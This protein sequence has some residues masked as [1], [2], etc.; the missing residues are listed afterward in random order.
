MPLAPSSVS[1]QNPTN[2]AVEIHKTR[3]NEFC[4]E[5][6]IL[7]SNSRHGSKLT[8]PFHGVL[9]SV[10]G[11]VIH[12]SASSHFDGSVLPLLNDIN[13][14]TLMCLRLLLLGKGTR[15]EHQPF[16]KLPT[17]LSP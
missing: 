13:A 15:S 4:Y 16:W 8:S 7:Q 6:G 17:L 12:L 9:L 14:T 2:V 11:L 5:L 10:V 1:Y 3:S